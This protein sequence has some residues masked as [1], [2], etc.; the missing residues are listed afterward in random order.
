M[1]I[2][3]DSRD[4]GAISPEEYTKMAEA[5]AEYNKVAEAEALAIS[6]SMEKVG[7]KHSQ[8]IVNLRVSNDIDIEFAAC[9]LPLAVCRL[10]FAASLKFRSYAY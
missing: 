1:A 7:T 6:I 3:S 4:A 10:L 2:L 9:C 5:E 8:V